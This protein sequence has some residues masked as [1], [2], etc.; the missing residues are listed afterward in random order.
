LYLAEII[1]T[2]EMSNVLMCN[3]LLKNLFKK[4]KDE[5]KNAKKNNNN[6]SKHKKKRT[7]HSSLV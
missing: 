4:K 2:K 3:D 1:L 6:N 7:V 5:K